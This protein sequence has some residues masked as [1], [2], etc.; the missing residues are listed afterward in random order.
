MSRV[1]AKRTALDEPGMQ[2]TSVRPTVPAT[3]RDSIAAEPT[4]SQL[5][6]RNSSP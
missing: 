3:A 6:I 5:S 1:M 4:S 2:N